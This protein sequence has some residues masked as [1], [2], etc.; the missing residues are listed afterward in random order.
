MSRKIINSLVM[1]LYVGEIEPHELLFIIDYDKILLQEILYELIRLEYNEI[2]EKLI[3]EQ[4]RNM[5]EFC[6]KLD[7]D[8]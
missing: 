5:L 7:I 8:R 1:N 4:G 6:Y 3:I 2:I